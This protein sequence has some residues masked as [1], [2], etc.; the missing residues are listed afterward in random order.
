[1]KTMMKIILALLCVA[2]PL[3]AV[4]EDAAR[5]M[6]E[7]YASAVFTDPSEIPY[8]AERDENGYL[9]PGAS[10]TSMRLVDEE[11]GEMESYATEGE[12][13]YENPALGLWAYLSP[14]VQ[15][16]II[17][18]NGNWDDF[19]QLWF[20][21]DVRFDTE[22][23]SFARHTYYLEDATGMDVLGLN[24]DGVTRGKKNQA[25]WPKTLAQ[26]DRMVIAVNGDFYLGRVNQDHNTGSILRQGQVLYEYNPRKGLS[27]PNLDSAALYPDGSMKVF[28]AAE[29]TAAEQ[30]EQGAVN[31]LSF[32]PWL[33]RDGEL[34]DYTGNLYD[35]RDPRLAVGMAEPGH[36][37][38]IDCEGHIP[39]N[40]PKGL[41]LNELGALLYYHG[42]NEAINL[43]G[44]NTSVLIFMGEKLN[45]TGKVTIITT[46]RN[47]NEL[48]GVGTSELVRTDWANG[49]PKKK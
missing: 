4:A 13:V 9:L 14:T 31:M 37:I 43:D 11:T 12:F 7:P 29:T 1:M 16:E 42:A 30:L 21:A 45:R 24:K 49:D 47:Q 39:N 20:V 44:G 33:V 19:E 28:D 46:P 27:F 25:I 3:A 35:H 5:V 2:L 32:G 6:P 8:P 23:E 15:V 41:T 10:T 34:R 18:Y 40:G 38:F 17:R 26:A 48:F 22:T 36:Y